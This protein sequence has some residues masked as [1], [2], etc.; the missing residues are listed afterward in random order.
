M[1]YG[2]LA[3][4][5]T[6]L[7]QASFAQQNLNIVKQIERANCTANDTDL[8]I[9]ARVQTR[10]KAQKFCDISGKT[11]VRKSEWDE[12]VTEIPYAYIDVCKYKSVHVE[13]SFFC[14]PA[15]ADELYVTASAMGDFQHQAQDKADEQAQFYCNSRIKRV[16]NYSITAYPNLSYTIWMA[17]AHYRCIPQT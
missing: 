10:E 5:L 1:R 14:A 15:L 6:C 12:S 16:S 13:A 3:L 11:A 9:S 7:S 8:L 4:Y 2:F 17:S